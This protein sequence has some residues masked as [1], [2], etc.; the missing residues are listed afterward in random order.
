[1]NRLP[2][3]ASCALVALAAGAT[4]PSPAAPAASAA[5]PAPARPASSAPPAA[6]ATPAAPAAST[7]PAVPAADAPPRP[8]SARGLTNLV[9]FARLL[10]YVRYFHPSDQAA[11]A[12]WGS[13]A[14]AAIAELDPAES[15]ATAPAGPAA[16]APTGPAWT[17]PAG[18]DWPTPARP[19]WTEQAGA[20]IVAPAAGDNLAAALQ[21]LFAPLAP[22]LRVFAAGRR[23]PALDL[24]PPAGVPPAELRVVGWRHTGLGVSGGPSLFSS[25]RFNG[26]PTGP[27]TSALGGPDPRVPFAAD[28][29]GS[30]VCLLPLAVWADASGTLP[31]VPG[32]PAGGAAAAAAAGGTPAA[33]A[34]VSPADRSSRLAIVMLAWNVLQ[35]FDP[36]LAAGGVARAVAWR[37]ALTAALEEAAEGT[38]AESLLDTLRRMAAVTD[39]GQATVVAAG[40]RRTFGLPLRWD[41]IEG[42]LVVTE[43]GAG[44]PGLQPGD[45]VTRIEGR[46]VRSQLREAEAAAP[47][48]TPQWRRWRALANLALGERGEPVRLDVDPPGPA[49][50]GSGTKASA[51]RAVTVTHGATAGQL[52]AAETRLEAVREARPGVLV[53][54]LGRLSERELDAALPRLA[55]A[56]GIVFDLRGDVRSTDLLLAHLVAA[57]VDPRREMVP[58]WPRPD[59]EAVRYQAAGTQ[60]AP[61][62]PRLQGRLAFLTSAR[63][64]GAAES[65]LATVA[66]LHLGAIVGS[67]TGGA[68]GSVDSAPLPAGFTL[69]WT[70]TRPAAGTP[71]A[72]TP[73]QPTVAVTPTRRGIAAGRDEVLEKAL[74]LVAPP[75]A[76][77]GELPRD[78]GVKPV[79][80]VNAINAVKAVKALSVVLAE[81]A[82]LAALTALPTLGL[83]PAADFPLQVV[84]PL[85]YVVDYEPF[86]SPDGHRI[87]LISSRHGGMK[88][89]VLEASGG[90]GSDMRQLTTGEAEDDSPAWSPDGRRIAFVSIRGGVSQLFVMNADGTEIRQL[91]RGTGENIHP[92]WSPDG[93]RILFNTTHFADPAR[94]AAAKV[95]EQR[96]I[97]ERID[98]L[99]ELATI[100]PN[101]NDLRRLTRDGGYTYASFSP[102][103][104]AIVHRRARG[105]LSQIYVMKADGTGD[106]NLS[107]DAAVDGWPAWSA[108]GKRI[109]FSRRVQERFQIFVMNRDGSGVRQLTAAQGELTNPRWSPD[110]TKI[111]CSRRLGGINLVLLDAP[112]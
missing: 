94:A 1:M 88:V 99:M 83:S 57:P 61:A 98:E 84:K 100:S 59:R 20:E 38:G 29:G 34:P 9:A 75:P 81:P 45:A 90:N 40:D 13:F 93:A 89:H 65:L 73:V 3:L 30:A 4:R 15:A 24:G 104:G 58:T 71:P 55:A 105:D 26:E 47:A 108:D 11:A 10:G 46:D 109:V 33:A 79:N 6:P 64:V 41:W 63:D 97:G 69:A 67:P 32:T 25:V 27:G 110:G 62:A 17:T 22:T 56:T 42:Q 12:D 49:A 76:A 70:A 50:G 72:G 23:P 78:Q 52:T 106:H 96:V 87:V 86:W 16:T 31:H 107:A 101:G 2:L 53:V 82:A 111:L 5:S 44:V 48:A 68:R 80:A 91:T 28:L 66:E 85:T 37:N 54:D 36:S 18:S 21:R 77:S 112:R 35:H 14:A 43:V 92:A 74:A 103:G 102:D 95:V 7:T 60:V 51:T 19:A 39:D 8:L